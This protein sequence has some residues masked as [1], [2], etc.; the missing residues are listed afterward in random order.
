A[1][2]AGEVRVGDL[3]AYRDFVDARDVAAAAVL[4]ATLARPLPPVLNIGSGRATCV[5][6]LAAQL[7][8]V[9]GVLVPIIETGGSSNRSDKVSW[10]CADNHAARTALGWAPRHR[11]ADSLGELWHTLSGA[12]APA[13][14]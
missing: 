11:L 1:G 7:A 6:D 3:S 2:P 5:R 12:A 9:A 13:A 10:S 8:D 4:A 14:R